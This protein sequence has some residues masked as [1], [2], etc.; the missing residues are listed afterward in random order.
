M[1]SRLFNMCKLGILPGLQ[2]VREAYK[3]V[4]NHN[5]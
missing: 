4:N 3:S 1:S 5:Q 2:T